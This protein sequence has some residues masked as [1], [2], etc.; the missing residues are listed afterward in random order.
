MTTPSTLAVH[1]AAHC[2][3][4]MHYGVSI[5]DVC[6]RPDGS[7]LV[8]HEPIPDPFEDAVV[9]YAGL[10]AEKRLTNNPDVEWWGAIGDHAQARHRLEKLI[11]DPIMR[12]RELQRVEHCARH[13]VLTTWP[14]IL[15]IA[16]RLDGELV[17]SG[18]P[19]LTLAKEYGG[20]R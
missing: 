7:G 12:Q 6:I 20:T 9:A 2:V 19:V 1:E 3:A 13:I 10:E 16:N 17:L 11:P 8:R 14:L 4:L 15:K 5:R 18:S